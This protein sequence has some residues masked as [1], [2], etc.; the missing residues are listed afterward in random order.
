MEQ[1]RRATQV[2]MLAHELDGQI[3]FLRT[4]RIS[5]KDKVKALLEEYVRELATKDFSVSPDV[6]DDLLGIIDALDE[7][8]FEVV[9][10]LE[11]QFE[12]AVSN[13]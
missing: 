8:Y 1:D 10:R 3:S 13:L 9:A 2:E 6:R 11:E 12:D 5:Y 7:P 4:T